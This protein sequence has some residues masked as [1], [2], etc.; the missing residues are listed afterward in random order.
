MTNFGPNT[1]R[2]PPDSEAEGM[3]RI[4][5]A[6]VHQLGGAAYIDRAELERVASEH[7]TVRVTYDEMHNYTLKEVYE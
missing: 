4:I 2:P 6:L 3:R 7:A 5:T 1:L